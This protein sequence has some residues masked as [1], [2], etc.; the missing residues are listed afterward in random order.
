MMAFVCGR[1][2]K[3][4]SL[5]SELLVLAESSR[6]TRPSSSPTATRL[7]VLQLSTQKGIVRVAVPSM[8]VD[9]KVSSGRLKNLAVSSC[10]SK[11]L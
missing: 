2:A 6:R 11:G 8:L 9:K 3:K 7:F 5:K 1:N 4:G 10:Q